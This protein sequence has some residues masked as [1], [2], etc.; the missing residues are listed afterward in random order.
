MTPQTKRNVLG[1]GLAALL[2]ERPEANNQ[3]QGEYRYSRV[4][5]IYPCPD[6]PRKKFLEEQLEQLAQSIRKVGVLQPLLVRP[7]PNGGVFLIAGERR[8]RAAQRAGL[9]ELPVVIKDIAPDEAF[10]RALI[11]NI[12]RSDLNPIEE[13][14]AYQRL[15]DEF[16][17]TQDKI[18]DR[19]GKSRSTVANSLR[20]L[21]LPTRVRE[22]VENSQL[23]MGHARALLAVKTTNIEACA[24][25]VVSKGL[26]VRDTERLARKD[27]IVKKSTPIA[28]TPVVRDLENRLTQSLGSQT[29]VSQNKRGKGGRI[30]IR[31]ADLD[32]LDRL[33]EQLLK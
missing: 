22:M 30:E 33:L 4:E 12:Q 9:S 8:W 17:L 23:S 14:L 6:Q 18:A 19:V 21:Q 3:T 10:E 16:E 11:E 27:T 32:D 28:K 31:Y 24:H 20:L 5:D 2:P 13:A 1:R 7:R 26:S 15:I 25:Q 29:F